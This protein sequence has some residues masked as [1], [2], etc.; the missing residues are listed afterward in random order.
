MDRVFQSFCESIQ[1]YINQQDPIT[2]FAETKR[3]DY[4]ESLVDDPME[5]WFVQGMRLSFQPSL[6]LTGRSSLEGVVDLNGSGQR[7][8]SVE[9]EGRSSSNKG[10]RRR[11][12]S[13]EDEGLSKEE[14]VQEWLLPPGKRVSHFFAPQMKT[15]LAG[16]Q[17]IPHHQ[18]G[19]PAEVCLRYQIE[20]CKMGKGCKLNANA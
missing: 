17:R 19:R 8:S 11:P 9:G 18:S 6:I 16:I 15:N 3:A 5:K 1:L 13:E 2:F 7:K 4:M 10:T 14:Y 20:K 12:S